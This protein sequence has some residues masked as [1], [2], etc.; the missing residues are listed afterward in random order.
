MLDLIPITLTIAIKNGKLTYEEKKKPVL[1]LTELQIE[2]GPIR[3]VKPEPGDYPSH[4]HV[5]AAVQNGGI[6]E[7]N[8][9]VNALAQP[10]PAGMVDVAVHNVDL[11][12][13][14]PVADRHHIN[15]HQGRVAMDAHAHYA[16]GVKQF[17]VRDLTV[18]KMVTNY[19]YKP[20]EPKP[21]K[22]KG[23]KG[24]EKAAEAAN[25]PETVIRI[26]RATITDSEFGVVHAGVDPPYRVFLKHTSAELK[27]FSNRLK[28][29]KA[30]VIAKGQLM[31]SGNFEARGVFRPAEAPDF[32]LSVKVERTQVKMLN[33]LLRAHGRLDVAGGTLSVYSQFKVQEGRI[34]GYVKN[35]SSASWTCTTPIRN[36]ARAW[37]EN[38]TKVSS[39][40][41]RN[42]LATQ[43]PVQPPR[44][45]R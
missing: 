29:K 26:E 43:R 18:D 45:Y 44:R 20:T 9:T 41:P 38:C 33:D 22:E 3:N 6:L 31:A 28:E 27:D 40:A 7:L 35:R 12:P 17:D 5:K 23:K 42:C 14:A 39:V 30:E 2:A 32:D 36:R 10:N 37:S 19:V 1:Q 21:E 15:L 11:T 25:Q 8:G 34:E 16:P 13:F 24:A 4:V